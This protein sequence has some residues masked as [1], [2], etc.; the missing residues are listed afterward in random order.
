MPWLAAL[1]FGL[2]LGLGFGAA[3]GFVAERVRVAPLWRSAFAGL[4][5]MALAVVSMTVLVFLRE[6][7]LGYG[8]FDVRL[9]GRGI[10]VCAALIFAAFAVLHVVL[11]RLGAPGHQSR[12]AVVIGCIGG[13]IGALPLAWALIV[14]D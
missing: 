4:L 6:R 2:G 3:V 12:F 11:G 9:S 7:A 13:L 14:A 1:S 5:A 10:A 8:V